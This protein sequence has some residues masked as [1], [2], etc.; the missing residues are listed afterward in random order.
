MIESGSWD[1]ECREE[2][3][4]CWLLALRVELH[5]WD[6]Q[7]VVVLLII[8]VV[9]TCLT[10]FGVLAT[11]ADLVSPGVEF[12][13]AFLE[14]IRALRS[15][16]SRSPSGSIVNVEGPDVLLVRLRLDVGIGFR[17]TEHHLQNA[18]TTVV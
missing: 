13:L 2:R 5:R 12:T 18:H 17:R 4:G 3:D 14:R 6:R 16:G 1:G 7:E 8:A 10:G 11:H 15:E 9:F